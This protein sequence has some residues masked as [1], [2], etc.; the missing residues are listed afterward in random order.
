M[1]NTDFIQATIEIFGSVIL[2]INGCI[3]LMKPM[4]IIEGTD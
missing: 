3:S 2:S 1:A 4:Y